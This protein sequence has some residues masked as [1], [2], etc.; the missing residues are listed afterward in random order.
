M[1]Y[2][3]IG[4]FISTERKAKKLT[5]AKLGEML[6]VSEKTISK[7]ENGNGVPDTSTLPKLCEI[8][9]ISINELLNGER[10]SVDEYKTQAETKLFELQEAKNASEKRLLKTEI[11]IGV[12]TTLWFFFVLFISVYMIEKLNITTLPAILIIVSFV[13]TIILIFYCLYLEQVAGYYICK[14]CN[15]KYIPTFK[16]VFFAKHIGRTRNMKC[17]KCHQRTWNKKIIK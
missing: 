7:W 1:D 17:P 16:Q 6:F 2:E 8:L 3:K 4:N 10:L 12:S 9:D 15:H 14:H 13:F 11:V 5:Q